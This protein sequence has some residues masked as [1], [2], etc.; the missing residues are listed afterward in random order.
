MTSTARVQVNH[1]ENTLQSTPQSKGS[2]TISEHISTVGVHVSDIRPWVTKD[3][4]NFQECSFDEMLKDFLVDCSDRPQESFGGAHRTRL[5]K[6]CL[7]KVLPICIGEAQSKIQGDIRLSKLRENLVTYNLI[8]A[9]PRIANRTSSLYPNLMLARPAPD[10][11]LGWRN[12]R[13]FVEFKRSTKKMAVPPDRYTLKEITPPQQHEYLRMDVLNDELEPDV[14]RA[15]PPPTEPVRRSTRQREKAVATNSDSHKRTSEH[16]EPTSSQSKRQ[17]SEHTKS[18]P[19]IVQAGYYAA[20]MFT[21][22]TARQHVIGV[23]V[24]GDVLYVWRYDRERTIQC[25]GLN[26]IED[27]PRFLVLLLAMQRFQAKHWGLNPHVDPK[28]CLTPSSEETTLRGDEGKMIQVVFGLSDET[29]VTHFGL[30]GRATNVLSVECKDLSENPDLVS[31]LFW[32]EIRRM[33]E[34]DI[35]KKVYEISETD[36][37]V[38]GHVPEM[39]WFKTFHDTATAKIRERLGLKT[40]GTRVLCMIIF[41][42]LR[43]I[44]ELQGKE[45]L[46]A[47]WVTVITPS[48]SAEFITETLAHKQKQIVAVLNDFDLASTHMIA[49]GTRRT[50][51][52]PFMAIALLDEAA[53]QGK[54]AHVYEYDAE[55]F[56]WTLISAAKRDCSKSRLSSRRTQWDL[57]STSRQAV[58]LQFAIGIPEGGPGCK[59]L[60]AMKRIG[61]WLRKECIIVLRQRGL[62][63][64]ELG[65]DA[66][67]DTDS[68]FGRLLRVPTG[69]Y[70]DML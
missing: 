4:E 61:S 5:F 3:V 11:K 54:I 31:K 60:Q 20:E 25:S 33:S 47:W 34:P 42:K 56:I 49:T 38:K 67:L 24:V 8:K 7:N 6:E 12:V 62:E 37:D 36:P 66:P 30:N 23:V 18:H 48:G 70:V 9:K 15:R 21:A 55:S 51:T 59:L 40:E 32:M 44:T 41:R 1:L 19:V 53:L 52:V 27:L 45:F 10:K 46:I 57:P 35:L 65:N 26:F 2:A 50:G 13:T 43:P 64:E 17:K 14:L 63:R 22:Y 16:L 69:H 29:R 58:A 68:A 28:F 39:M